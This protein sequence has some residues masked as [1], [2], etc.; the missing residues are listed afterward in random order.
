MHE[1]TLMKLRRE[2]GQALVEYVLVTSLI[3]LVCVFALTFLG[4]QLDAMFS[5]VDIPGV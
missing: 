5:E 3:A 2:E 1:L 4:D